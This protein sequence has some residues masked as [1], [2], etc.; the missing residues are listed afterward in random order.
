M[1]GQ[2]YGGVSSANKKRVTTASN[3]ALRTQR[4]KGDMM[5]SEKEKRYSARSTVFKVVGHGCQL[6]LPR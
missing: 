1:A 5:R 2:S 6:E 4:K 3:R